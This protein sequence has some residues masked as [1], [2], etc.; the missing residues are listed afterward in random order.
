MLDKIEML[1]PGECQLQAGE[2]CLV[3]VSGGPD[4]ICLLHALNSLGYPLVAVH[5]NHTLRPEANQEAQAVEAFAKGLGIDCITYRVDVRGYAGEQSLSIEE[6]ARQLRYACL[7]EQAEQTSAGAVLVAHNADDQVE[8][9]LMHVLR[10][11]GLS[12]LRGMPYRALPNQWSER[13]PLVRP[14]LSTW[15]GE[16]LEYL[17]LNHLGYIFDQSN[18][19]TA[20][21]RNQLRHGLLPDLEKYNPRIRQNLL[22]VGRISRE[23][24]AVI[25][26]LVDQAW[27]ANLARQ[28]AGY[29]SF[30][31]DGFQQLP[32]S[33]QRY[34]LR[35]AIAYHLPSLKDVDFASIERGVNFLCDGKE[36]GQADLI[37]GLRL[38]KEG[39]LFWLASWQADLPGSDYPSIPA[40]ARLEVQVPGGVPLNDSWV[41]QA[42]RETDPG[43][44][45]QH[46]EDNVDPFQ[47][48]ID[49]DEVELPLVLRCRKAG[50]RFQPLGMQ[51]HSMK[52]SDLMVNQKVPKRTRATWPLVCSGEAV[53]WI[54]GLRQG[55][56]VRIRPTSRNI[57][58]LSLSRG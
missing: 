27:K 26:Q 33:I 9:I 51:G 15:R 6:A 49:L 25:Q 3:G 53:I 40:G 47:A 32:A 44:A 13:I 11:S 55:Y 34:L 2:L 38:V 41:F 57:A 35:R 12:G 48:W 19:D 20:F 36:T 24:Y 56:R 52:I 58:H 7:F 17:S 54:P 22:R 1:L 5:V 23:D 31:L 4:S 28:G 45:I 29:L 50:E 37:A 16:I 39:D 43:D 21:F 46:G 30:R 14:L 18:A 42:S 8:T 10:G